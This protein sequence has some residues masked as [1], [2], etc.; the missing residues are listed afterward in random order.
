MKAPFAASFSTPNTGL[1]SICATHALKEEYN[2]TSSAFCPLLN[3]FHQ[4]CLLALGVQA[5]Y[6]E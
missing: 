2:V 3:S 4:V 5:P 1:T 6:G